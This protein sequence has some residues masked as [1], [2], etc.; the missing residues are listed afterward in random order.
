MGRDEAAVNVSLEAHPWAV[1][2][3]RMSD[4]T[5][6]GGVCGWVS[7]ACTGSVQIGSVLGN[8]NEDIDRNL[9]LFCRFFSPCI[10]GSL[11]VNRAK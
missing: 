2:S 11:S 7:Y 5:R 9:K 10:T 8:G 6:S 4:E 1:A 3:T